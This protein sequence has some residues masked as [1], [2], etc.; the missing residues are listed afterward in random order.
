M[1]ATLGLRMMRQTP[2]LMRAAP[3]EDQA[4]HGVSQRLRKLKNVPPEL[5]PLG[6]VVGFA[7]CAA[8]YSLGRH[9]LTDKTIRLSRQGSEHKAHD[10][11]AHSEGH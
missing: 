1:Y 9:L 10:T 5:F 3:V 2:R 6:V 8:G 4:G 7:V 11:K